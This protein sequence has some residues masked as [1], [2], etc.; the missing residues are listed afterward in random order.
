MTLMTQV[1]LLARVEPRGQE[2]P[3]VYMVTWLDADKRIQSGTVISLKGDE[4]KWLIVDVYN[5]IERSEID[6]HGWDNNNYDKHEGLKL[7]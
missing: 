6:Q 2:K 1:K 3:M 4:R 7:K 5:T